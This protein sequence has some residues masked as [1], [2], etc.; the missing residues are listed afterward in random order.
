[1][2]TYYCI[3]KKIR[4]NKSKWVLPVLVGAFILTGL[5]GFL[6][7]NGLIHAAVPPKI[8]K[9]SAALSDKDWSKGMERVLFNK[10]LVM[11][12]TGGDGPKTLFFGDSNTQMYGP[13][14]T[15]L[16]SENKG[17]TRGAIL[18]TCGGVPPIPNVTVK[19]RSDEC[20]LLIEKFNQ[21]IST[22]S[23][24]DRVVIAAL[25]QGY[26]KSASTYQYKENPMCEKSGRDAAL[27]ELGLLI[28]G[29]VSKGKEVTLVLSV[30]SSNELDPRGWYERTFHRVC[31]VE[32]QGRLKT[33]KFLEY[34]GEMLKSLAK[35]AKE[36]QLTFAADL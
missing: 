12:K 1:M 3:E 29:L 25:W 18:L 28:R 34:Y 23:T 17:Q 26:F 35:V 7:A 13:R 24:I 27:H 31:G 21:V 5:I 2:L 16:L 4:H 10:T 36:N 19:N 15:K 33:T 14:I 30:P 22:D 11:D 20:R 9:L 8:Q 6:V 32:N